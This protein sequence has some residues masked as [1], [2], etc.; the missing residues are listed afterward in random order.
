MA[1]FP[2]I[3]A[4]RDLHR[5]LSSGRRSTMKTPPLLTRGQK[6]FRAFVDSIPACLNWV[7]T[8]IIMLYSGTGYIA[9]LGRFTRGW[10][11]CSR[12]ARMHM[13]DDGGNWVHNHPHFSLPHFFH[14]PHSD[15]RPGILNCGSAVAK[16][17]RCPAFTYHARRSF[18]WSAFTSKLGQSITPTC[19][20]KASAS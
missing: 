2:E 7:I 6:E 13:V 10:H 16:V 9:G 18:R 15:T 4:G 1:P 8:F 14:L 20:R 12:H 17:G 11:G 19:A 5:V 3:K